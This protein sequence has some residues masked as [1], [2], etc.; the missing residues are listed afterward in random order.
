MRELIV[1]YSSKL[2]EQYLPP[3][4]TAL[5]IKKLIYKSRIKELYIGNYRI[6]LFNAI[7]FEVRT[8]CNNKCSFCAASVQNE[9]RKDIRMH[10]E[11]YKKVIRQLKKLNYSGKIAYHVNN[12]PLIFPNLPRFIL[13][14]RKNVPNAWIQVLTNGKAL[15]LAKADEM[16][17]AGINELTI[18]YYNDN[19]KSQ[20]PEI[21]IKIREVI[22]PKYYHTNQ[23]KSGHKINRKKYFRFNIYRR[24]LNEILT[25]RAGTSPNKKIIK[26]NYLGFCEYPFTQFN[27]TSDGKVSKCC[28]DLFFSDSMG[29]VNQNDLLDIWY[30]DKFNNVRNFLLQNN[31]LAIETCRRCDYFGVKKSVRSPL[32]KIFYYF[33]K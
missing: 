14:A 21:F 16:I 12:D 13:I 29:D 11:L 8:R 5:I 17:E 32:S 28:A 19:I 15:S 1:K 20:L 26:K 23:I 10:I 27:I 24:K 18:N 31:R 7:Y 33:M 30:G 2:F 25:T 22:L 3:S 9:K 4:I 6:P